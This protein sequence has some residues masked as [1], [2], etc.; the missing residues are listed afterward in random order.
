MGKEVDE[1]LKMKQ[2]ATG[3]RSGEI[4][5]EVISQF[6]QKDSKSLQIR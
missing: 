4:S 1:A 2:E 3:E 6:W 5:E